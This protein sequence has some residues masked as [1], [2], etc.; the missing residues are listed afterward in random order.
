MLQ[1]NK[2]SGACHAPLPTH[3]P[4][5]SSANPF[6]L[7]SQRV[8]IK[9]KPQKLCK[10]SAKEIE[11]IDNLNPCMPRT[12]TRTRLSG[13]NGNS[14]LCAAAYVDESIAMIFWR[15]SCLPRLPCPPSH[16]ALHLI[17]LFTH[18]GVALRVLSQVF[19]MRDIRL[20]R[21]RRHR[22]RIWLCLRA[23]SLL[24]GLFN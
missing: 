2:R 19:L 15:G 22:V 7:P 10:N 3:L 8:A 16:P 21:R 6:K 12:R 11:F 4:S 14:F 24:E 13:N 5:Y 23:S 20:R 9:T 1:P 17:K 18:G